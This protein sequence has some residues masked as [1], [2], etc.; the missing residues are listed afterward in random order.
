[1]VRDKGLGNRLR[2]AIHAA[3]KGVGGELYIRGWTD[4]AALSHYVPCTTF[5]LAALGGNTELKLNLVETHA[6]LCMAGNFAVRNSAAD[7]DDHG[8]AWLLG[9][10]IP[11]TYYK[12]E[13]IAFAITNLNFYF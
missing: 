5:A 10:L 1:M 6:S 13:S 2:T 11:R 8:L 3:P 12:C 4:A 7:T 9:E